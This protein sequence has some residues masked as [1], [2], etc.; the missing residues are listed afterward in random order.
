MLWTAAACPTRTAQQVSILY[1]E[2]NA[3]CQYFLPFAPI[4]SDVAA[5]VNLHGCLRD[6]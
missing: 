6:I 3:M 4:Y 2:I 5:A 1:A